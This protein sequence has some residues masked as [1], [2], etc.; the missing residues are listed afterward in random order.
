MEEEPHK[1][2]RKLVPDHTGNDVTF[3]FFAAIA[4]FFGVPGVLSTFACPCLLVLGM[5]GADIGSDITPF[6][7][8]L[9]LAMGAVPNLL[10]GAVAW[11]IARRF[12][13]E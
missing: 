12:W 9:L 5:I 4:V 1:A 6:G 7:L 10:I 2:P 11:L 13:V 3:F 8:S